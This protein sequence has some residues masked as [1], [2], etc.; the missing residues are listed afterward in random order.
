MART[1]GTIATFRT[2]I[3]NANARLAAEEDVRA[4]RLISP[5]Q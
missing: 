1:G 4:G 5:W 3:T 2:M